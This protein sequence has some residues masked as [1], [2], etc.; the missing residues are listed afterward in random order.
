[1]CIGYLKDAQDNGF[2]FGA[3]LMAPSSLSN[4]GWGA[5]NENSTGF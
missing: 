5:I 1:M 3:K 4:K 2:F